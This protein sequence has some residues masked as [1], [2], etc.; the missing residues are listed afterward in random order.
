MSNDDIK[1]DNMEKISFFDTENNEEVE[2]YV[3]EQTTLR[4]IKY[5]LVAEDNSDESEAYI[6]RQ[7]G[8]SEEDI[9]Y[10]PVEDDNEYEALVKVFAELLDDADIISNS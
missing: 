4:G 6:F 8:E 5:L 3:L 9:I 2:L 7:E 1:N 10:T